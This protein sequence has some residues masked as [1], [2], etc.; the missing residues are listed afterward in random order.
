MCKRS[1]NQILMDEN[2]RKESLNKL[3]NRIDKHFNNEAKIM[4]DILTSN[5]SDNDFKELI[6]FMSNHPLKE[7]IDLLNSRPPTKN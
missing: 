6:E 5:L 3:K 4:R 1:Q 2:K 7:C